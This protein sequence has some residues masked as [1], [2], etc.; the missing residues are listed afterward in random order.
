MEVTA[1]NWVL[2]QRLL[3]ATAGTVVGNRYP[4]NFDVLHV[5]AARPLA[6]VADG[7]GDGPGSTAAGRTAVEVFV[8]ETAT[9][10][11]PAALRAAV[12]GVQRAV[13][14]A[15][16]GIAGL[17]GCTLTAFAGDTDGSAWLVQLGDSRA[18]RLRDGVFELLTSDH[19]A[20][21]LGILNGWYAA[22]SR[23][24][25]RDR[26]HLTRYAGHPGMPEP[27]L[28]NVSLC[29]GDRFLLCTDGVSDQLHDRRLADALAE[30]TTVAELLA[31]TLDHGG[32]DNATAV[33]VQVS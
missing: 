23:E 30:R 32:D 5:D 31:E 25:V 14:D 29:P 10:T 20:A 1:A 16:R 26:H 2:G 22:D 19:T 11:G 9:A 27:D 12:A 7:M 8:R 13:R 3:S 18:Y 33:I 6:V 17:T 4:A 28:L 24:A 21:W 15:G